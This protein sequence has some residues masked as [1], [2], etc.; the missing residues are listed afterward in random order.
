MCAC[1]DSELMETLPQNA[2]STQDAKSVCVCVFTRKTTSLK[3]SEHLHV[4]HAQHKFPFDFRAKRKKFCASKNRTT[5]FIRFANSKVFRIYKVHNLYKFGRGDAEKARFISK[6]MRLPCENERVLAAI[7]Q[8]CIQIIIS[9]LAA[10]TAC[11][12]NGVRKKFLSCARTRF[13][14]N[15]KVSQSY[16][17]VCLLVLLMLIALCAHIHFGLLV[18]SIWRCCCQWWRWWK[19]TMQLH[20][21]KFTFSA[22]LRYATCRLFGFG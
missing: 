6:R 12:R 22:S 5:Q 9:R 1:F 18:R 19:H 20:E 17:C 4:I 13:P 14:C 16:V 7:F 15:W 2:H 21:I 3:I 10:P 8:L 11:T